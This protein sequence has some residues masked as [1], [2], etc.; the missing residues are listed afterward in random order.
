MPRLAA[1][2][3][4]A[5]KARSLVMISSTSPARAPASHTPAPTAILRSLQS[6][7][8]T[9]GA[10]WMRWAPW[11]ASR[12]AESWP[13]TRQFP[14]ATKSVRRPVRSTSRC[15]ITRAMCSGRLAFSTSKKIARRGVGK[16]RSASGGSTREAKR[17]SGVSRTM[18]SSTGTSTGDFGG[19]RARGSGLD[20]GRLDG[21]GRGRAA[22]GR[23]LL[24]RLRLLPR[25]A[26]SAS[27]ARDSARAGCR[28][29][30]V[31][32]VFFFFTMVSGR[33]VQWWVMRWWEKPSRSAAYQIAFGRDRAVAADRRDADTRRRRAP[34]PSW[35]RSS[36]GGRSAPVRRYVEPSEGLRSAGRR[37]ASEAAA[38]RGPG[39]VE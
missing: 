20:H 2:S 22:A 6:R 38:C 28:L 9:D 18:T 12:R 19:Q 23:G 39:R 24:P 26:A 8:P 29:G 27:C 3:P 4:T 14:T 30:T 10:L 5:S 11:R 33:A 31:F 21:G 34:C 1:T 25:L 16:G 36:S 15:S 7:T 37:P 17:G 13:I 32:D 35:C